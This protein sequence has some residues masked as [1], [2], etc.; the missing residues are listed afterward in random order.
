MSNKLITMS[1]VRTEVESIK[2]HIETTETLQQ[3]ASEYLQYRDIKPDSNDEND[4]IRVI[5]LCATYPLYSTLID[6]VWERL[7]G[8]KDRLQSV[9]DALY[10]A[11]GDE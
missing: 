1:D 9:V 5:E 3:I 7:S 4:R 8:I 6:V 2:I 10:N 11:K